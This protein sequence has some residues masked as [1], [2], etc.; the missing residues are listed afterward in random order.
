MLIISWFS[1]HFGCFHFLAIWSNIAIN[2]SHR[3]FWGLMLSCLLLVH[4]C[5]CC[6]VAK[7]CPVLYDPLDCSPPG[8]SVHGILQERILVWVAMPSSR[9]SSQPRN[10][11]CLSCITG[12]FLTLWATMEAPWYY[13]AAKLL[14]LLILELVLVRSCA[15]VPPVS[16]R[17][18]G[19]GTGRTLGWA[20]SW[21]RTPLLQA[22]PQCFS[23]HKAEG[24]FWNCGLRGWEKPEATLPGS[25]V[26]GQSFLTRA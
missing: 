19:V 6:L 24:S 4:Y 16:S 23:L 13:L 9:G 21:G 14:K 2:I 18:A 22:E 12:G 26:W 15:S 10:W 17:W 7:S 1:R 20:D 25:Q 5:C 3:V 8:S 11:T